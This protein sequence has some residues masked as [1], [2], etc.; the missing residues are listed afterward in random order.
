MT[1]YYNV[2][3]SVFPMFSGALYFSHAQVCGSTDALEVYHSHVK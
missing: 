1:F 3:V 2:L